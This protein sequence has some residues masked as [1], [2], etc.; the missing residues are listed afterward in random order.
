MLT[1]STRVITTIFLLASAVC[2]I[3]ENQ[4]RAAN[5]RKFIHSRPSEEGTLAFPYGIIFVEDLAYREGNKN[6]WTL[7]LVMPKTKGNQKFP[8]L[9]FVHGGLWRHGD[10]QH[11]YFRSGAIDFARKGFVC[12]SV[13]YRL[14][15][16][17]P[18]P[19]CMEDVKCAVRWLRAHAEKYNVDPNRIGGF[20][21]SAGAHLTC[22]MG[23]ENKDSNL[24]KNAPWPNYSSQLNAVAAAAAPTDFSNWLGDFEGR[25]ILRNLLEAP[26][27]ILEEQA[28]K[29]S[30]I[31]YVHQQTPPILLF[32]GIEDQVV[33]ISQADRFVEALK[34]VGAKDISYHRFEG[35]GHSVFKQRQKQTHAL[36]EA[37]FERT[38]MNP[39]TN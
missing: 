26:G 17:A 27:T 11:D 24:D 6:A 23:M 25:H 31:N 18:F 20:G 16:E 9:V 35:A 14:T 36:L 30:P 15:Q 3:P 10:K 12:I 34:A 21:D 2:L 8:A 7:D 29:A 28:R 1:L 5:K 37:F 19:A 13:N 32:H 4:N 22:L 38:L 33:D 39:E